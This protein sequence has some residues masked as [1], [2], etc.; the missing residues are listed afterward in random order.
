MTVYMVSWLDPVLHRPQQFDAARPGPRRAQ[1]AET[2]RRR[3]GYLQL[4]YSI[5]II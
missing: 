5:M 2:Q 4:V 3:V 1:V